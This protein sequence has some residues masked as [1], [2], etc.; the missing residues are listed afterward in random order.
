MAVESKYYVYAAVSAIAIRYG[1]SKHTLACT[2]PA[3]SGAFFKLFG[4]SGCYYLTLESIE[5]S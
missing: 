1:L 2:P 3:A 4:H 5:Q